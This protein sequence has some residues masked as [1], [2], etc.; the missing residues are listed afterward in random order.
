MVEACDV[1]AVKELVEE[2][3]AARLKLDVACAPERVP[4]ASHQLAA[5]LGAV[6]IGVV[7]AHPDEVLPE[8][9]VPS[10]HVHEPARGERLTSIISQ[11]A[12]PS[13][14]SRALEESSSKPGDLALRRRDEGPTAADE[15]EPEEE[16]KAAH[17][18]NVRRPAARPSSLA[19]PDIYTS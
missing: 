13:A 15:K 6:E 10:R 17:G 9:G 19:I 11:G 14:V 18:A 7:R 12:H 3:A 16:K 4:L 1:P 2:R 5:G 8:H